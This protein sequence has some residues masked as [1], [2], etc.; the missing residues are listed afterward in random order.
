MRVAYYVPTVPDVVST[1]R[2]NHALGL[3]NYADETLLLT[4]Q[5]PSTDACDAY[6]E[7]EV[8]TV[9]LDEDAG[10]LRRISPNVSRARRAVSRAEAFLDEDDV[11]VTTWQYAPALAGLFADRR[12]ILDVYD[13]P[14][15]KF[16]NNPRSIHQ[17]LARALGRI[18]R[19]SDRAVHTIHPS[20]PR[21]FGRERRFAINGAAT[22]TIEPGSKLP[23]DR[24]E[25]IWVGHPRLDRGME[26][27]LRALTAV[28]A[29]VHLDVYGRYYEEARALAEQL[30]VTD[31]VTF[32]GR[33]PHEDVIA[34][35]RTAHV[36]IGTYPY[37]VDW[38]YAYPIKVGEYMAAGTIPLCSPFTGSRE[39]ARGAGVYVEPASGP[40]ANRLER[41]ATLDEATF[42]EMAADCR[43][44]ADAVSWT[45]EREWFARQVLE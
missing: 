38:N 41:L 35:I 22:S 4:H 5:K 43:R 16:L 25:C 40:I 39:L 20:S 30:A 26:P 32:H 42:G 8:L 27:L 6:D 18:L 34:K 9:D 28:D 12:W 13:D 10:N 19:R 21:L 36:G 17:V 45:D 3:A 29:S 44:R 11:I 14:Y 31:S 23:L 2:Y 37:R 33:V 1:T 7:N 24:L 15:Q